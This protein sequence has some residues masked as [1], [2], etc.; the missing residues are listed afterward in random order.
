MGRDHGCIGSYRYHQYFNPRAPCGARPDC[1]SVRS[2]YHRISIHAPRVGR[3]SDIEP[4]PSPPLDFNPRAPCGAR[5]FHTWN[6]AKLDIFQSTR[7]VWGATSHTYGM[8]G[9]KKNFNPRAPC[10]ARLWFHSHKSRG[11]YFNPRAP[12]GARRRSATVSWASINISIH[13]PRVGRDHAPP[14]QRRRQELFQS[15]RPVWGATFDAGRLA[16][17]IRK[18]NP[19]AP[20]GARHESDKKGDQY[21]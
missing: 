19:R 9:G 10:G 12:C 18:F 5:P 16:P 1:C 20:C 3:D 4:R 14:A 2:C 17:L 8:R 13:A 21:L 7:P 6:T 15:T 11:R